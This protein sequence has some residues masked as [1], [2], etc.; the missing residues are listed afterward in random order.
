M[1]G[2]I[3]GQHEEERGQAQRR[4]K[5]RSLPLRRRCVVSQVDRV[6]A[7]G[8]R[9]D[10]KSIKRDTTQ[11]HLGD[12]R[13]TAREQRHGSLV[14]TTSI[15][16][17]SEVTQRWLALHNC[18][19]SFGLAFDRVRAG[20]AFLAEVLRR[21]PILFHRVDCSTAMRRCCALSVGLCGCT[22]LCSLS[23][24]GSSSPQIASV[25]DLSARWIGAARLDRTHNRP[26]QWY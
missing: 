3:D 17:V 24:D 23:R 10:G 20:I 11:S 21:A 16:A 15:T 6:G 5:R 26:M 7:D 13:G 9:M 25:R 4:R 14:R 19:P 1:Q 22:F 2:Q 8:A 18:L 12:T